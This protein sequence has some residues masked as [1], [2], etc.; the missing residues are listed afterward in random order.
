MPMFLH[1]DEPWVSQLCRAV[2]HRV[3]C[4]RHP[5]GRAGISLPSHHGK[6]IAA[7]VTA[8]RSGLL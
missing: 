1:G 2:A 7:R 8:S 4:F 5:L 6:G 3:R